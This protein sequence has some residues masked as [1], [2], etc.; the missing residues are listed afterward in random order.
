MEGQGGKGRIVAIEQRV[1]ATAFCYMLMPF[2]AHVKP[3]GHM[4]FCPF[5]TH[6]HAFN[7]RTIFPTDRADGT[8]FSHAV[9]SFPID[10]GKEKTGALAYDARSPVFMV[11]FPF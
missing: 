9:C 1:R 11:L 5:G 6:I 8:D 10:E 2:G 3:N 7:G 4:G